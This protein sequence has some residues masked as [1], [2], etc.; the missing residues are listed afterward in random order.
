[1]LQPKKARRATKHDFAI[2]CTAFA[3]NNATITTIVTTQTNKLT[4]CAEFVLARFGVNKITHCGQTKTGNADLLLAVHLKE[5]TKSII[6]VKLV[7]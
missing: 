4:Q 6:I 3:Q 1:M 2:A 7:V 5:I